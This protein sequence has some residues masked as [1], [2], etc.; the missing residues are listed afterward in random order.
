MA[1]EELEVAGKVVE[2]VVNGVKE[3]GVEGGG[4]G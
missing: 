4:V 3:A 2:G 1:R